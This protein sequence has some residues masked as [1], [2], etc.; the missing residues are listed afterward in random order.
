MTASTGPL[1]STMASPLTTSFIGARLPNSPVV[2]L[3]TWTP[4]S[5]RPA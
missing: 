1:L 5:A 4:S 2:F 3:N